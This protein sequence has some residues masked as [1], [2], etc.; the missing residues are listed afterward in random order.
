MQAGERFPSPLRG[1]GPA[2]LRV[3]TGQ[4]A[5]KRA[6]ADLGAFRGGM[7]LQTIKRFDG[8]VLPRAT[9]YLTKKTSCYIKIRRV[10]SVPELRIWLRSMT[11]ESQL[12]SESVVKTTKIKEQLPGA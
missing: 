7:L 4:P 1:E 5:V 12:S 9:L 10:L 3:A 8:T 6:L 2:G 11:L